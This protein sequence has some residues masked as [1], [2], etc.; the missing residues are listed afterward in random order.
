MRNQGNTVTTKRGL[1]I[2]KQIESALGP[3]FEKKIEAWAEKFAKEM[4][5]KFGEN[6]EFVK[7]ME[8]FGKEMEEKFGDDSEFAKK[9]EA[10]GKEMEKKFGPGS[11]FEKNMKEKFGPGSEF[12]KND[13]GEVRPWL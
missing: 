10:L 13:E 2:D 7:K 3:D 5:E 12:E 4:E 6:S 1:D 8:A 11:E 9:M